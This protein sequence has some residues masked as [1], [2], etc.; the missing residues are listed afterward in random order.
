MGSNFQLS[1]LTGRFRVQ[2]V[3]Q[4]SVKTK[5]VKKKEKHSI[6][7]SKGT[8]NKT[9]QDFKNHLD[10]V[11][12][13]GF[14][15][16]SQSVTLVLANG[17]RY[18]PDFFTFSKDGRKSEAWEVKGATNGKIYARDDAIAKLKMAARVYPDVIFRLVYKDK[19]T[20]GGWRMEEVLP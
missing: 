7:Q 13:K 20:P 4:M 18:T 16:Y 14:L 5:P 6:R 2:A 11:V 10:A 9:E 15:N 3:E 8:M 17:L 1:D 12:S 19:T